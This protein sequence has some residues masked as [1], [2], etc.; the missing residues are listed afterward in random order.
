MEKGKLEE[1]AGNGRMRI[2]D[3]KEAKE[4]DAFRTT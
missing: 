1:E 4:D 2:G 3:L